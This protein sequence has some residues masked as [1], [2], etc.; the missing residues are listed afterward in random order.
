MVLYITDYSQH[1]TVYNRL[2]PAVLYCGFWAG[3]TVTSND[4]AYGWTLWKRPEAGW[5]KA[6]V[7][8]CV[9]VYVRVCV[10]EF[11]TTVCIKES[12]SSY[13]SLPVCICL[14]V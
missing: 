7:C 4:N 9:C 11:V 5:D 8:V 12:K 6:G 1:G 2:Q 10:F 14:C 13:P 3:K